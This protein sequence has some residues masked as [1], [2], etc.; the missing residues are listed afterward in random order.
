MLV[1]PASTLMRNN[2]ANPP[3]DSLPGFPQAASAQP[4]KDSLILSSDDFELVFDE[5]TD[6]EKARMSAASQTEAASKPPE[7]PKTR[8]RSRTT[9]T[10]A[11]KV[12]A[13]QVATL[14]VDFVPVDGTDEEPSKSNPS[15]E[16]TPK[17][18]TK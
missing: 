10:R 17:T 13:E 3:E 4:A 1:T 8:K 7:K 18:D 12:L 11:E 14:A 5:P 9:S 6:S 15:Q 2:T 16:E